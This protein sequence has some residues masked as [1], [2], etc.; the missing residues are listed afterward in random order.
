MSVQ[1][2]RGRGDQSS[3][4]EDKITYSGRYNLFVYKREK[5][6]KKGSKMDFKERRV[7]Y[8]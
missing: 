3:R 1:E 7:V 5:G 6:S 4:G 8:L 2:L